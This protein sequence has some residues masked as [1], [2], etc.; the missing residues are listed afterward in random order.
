VSLSRVGTD[1]VDW[2]EQQWVDA[3]EWVGGLGTALAL[4][5]GLGIL[6][7][8]HADATRGQLDLVGAWAEPSWDIRGATEPRVEQVK[9]K[10]CVR[11]A[12]ELPVELAQLGYSVYTTWVVPE[13]EGVWNVVPGTAPVRCFPE[14]FIVR[15]GHIYEVT[16]YEPNVAH[17]A[18][19]ATGCSATSV[20]HRCPMP[21][22]L[23][24]D[25]GQRRKWEVLSSGF[26]VAVMTFENRWAIMTISTLA[27]APL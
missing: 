3:A 9:I 14:D 23:A 10:V 16:T 18:P 6:A 7:R 12:S 26:I 25:P 19:P 13:G 15:P 4:L 5:L 8:D 24:L 22:R 11:N 1:P 20:R 17:T 2:N 27:P 21:H